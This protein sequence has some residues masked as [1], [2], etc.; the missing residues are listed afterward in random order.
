[1]PVRDDTIELR[2]RANYD[3]WTSGVGAIEPVTGP[4]WSAVTRHRFGCFCEALVFF[5]NLRIGPGQRPRQINNPPPD[6]MWNIRPDYHKLVKIGV[7]RRHARTIPL[8][9]ITPQAMPK[10]DR[11]NKT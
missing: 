10:S 3:G 8:S 11:L 5:Q 7:I 4:I 9:Q 2:H 1:M 6:L